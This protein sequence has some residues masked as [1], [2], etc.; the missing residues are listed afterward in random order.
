ME[1]LEYPSHYLSIWCAENPPGSANR[2]HIGQPVLQLDDQRTVILLH[3]HF[4]TNDMRCAIQPIKKMAEKEWLALSELSALNP[5]IVGT[6]LNLKD[7]FD[8][9]DFLR[10]Y[11]K[12]IP[13]A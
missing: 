3:A 13:H 7:E 12:C 11:S 8:K 10:G 6:T 5:H 9:A 2:G 1:G 4:E